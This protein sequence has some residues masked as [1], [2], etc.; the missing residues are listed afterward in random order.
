MIRHTFVISR[1][2]IR[3]WTRK[4][5]D[6]LVEREFFTRADR[7]ELIDGQRS[8]PSHR[9]SITTAV[10]AIT[11]PRTPATASWWSKSR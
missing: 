2:S 5:Y 8:W 11:S 4:A 7:I 6:E 10:S 3:R 9:A 1:V